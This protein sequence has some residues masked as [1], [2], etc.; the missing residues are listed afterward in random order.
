MERKQLEQD[1]R[2]E[3]KG[4]SFINVSQTARVLGRSR[5]WT[6]T[7]LAD[8]PYERGSKAKRYYIPDVAKA[9][10]EGFY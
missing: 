4:A 9:Y 3:V 7:L 10:T 5:D 2:K 8:L 6:R 1:L